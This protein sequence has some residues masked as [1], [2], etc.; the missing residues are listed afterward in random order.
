MPETEYD[1]VTMASNEFT[2]IVRHD[3]S[4]LGDSFRIKV[5]GFPSEREAAN[6]SVLLRQIGALVERL[7]Q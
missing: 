7:R 4:Q 6:G 2:R 5:N 1:G 3:L